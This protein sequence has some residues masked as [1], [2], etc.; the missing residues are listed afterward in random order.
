[1]DLRNEDLLLYM[2]VC[3][4]QVGLNVSLNITTIFALVKRLISPTSMDFKNRKKCCDIILSISTL[5]QLSV[6]SNIVH[7]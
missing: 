3:L 7:F 5:S 6:L 2:V 4:N 1:M